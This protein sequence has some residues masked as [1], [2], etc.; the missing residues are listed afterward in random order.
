ML[1]VAQI[2]Q[3]DVEAESAGHAAHSKLQFISFLT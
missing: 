3:P 1:W 2:N